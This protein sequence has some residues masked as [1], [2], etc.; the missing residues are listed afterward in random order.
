[1]AMFLPM[2]VVGDHVTCALDDRLGWPE[3]LSTSMPAGTPLGQ[4]MNL[5]D[6]RNRGFGDTVRQLARMA[7]DRRARK[8]VGSVFVAMSHIDGRSCRLSP[9]EHGAGALVRLA[10]RHAS[11]LVDPDG[12]GAVWIVGPTGG[13]APWLPDGSAGEP[14]AHYSGYERWVQR[15]DRAVEKALK[16]DGEPAAKYISLAN[17]PR[18]HTKDGVVPNAPG[19]RWVAQRVIRVV[20]GGGKLEG[21]G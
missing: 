20:A 8:P 10:V 13:G 17:L 16:T 1:M 21:D 5:S 4:L 7:L 6:H 19:W 3:Y 9:D 11:T 12:G 18:K 15:V 2:I 14:P